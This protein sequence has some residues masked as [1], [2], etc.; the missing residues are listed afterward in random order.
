MRL[1]RSP[2]RRLL[3]RP[4]RVWHPGDPWT[5]DHGVE[6]PGEWTPTDVPAYVEQTTTQDVTVGGEVVQADW[7]L[8]APAGTAITAWDR[9]EVPDM[10]GWFEV[11]G[12]PARLRRAPSDA[13]HHIEA[14]LRTINTGATT[15]AIRPEPGVP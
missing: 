11:I 12:L 9:V 7:L 6:H 1:A 15:D 2:I 3:Q 4:I 5:D 10:G 14:R 8:L 13:E